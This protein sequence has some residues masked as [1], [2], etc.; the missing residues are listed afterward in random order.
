MGLTVLLTGESD[1]GEVGVDIATGE[2][3]AEVSGD[4]A[5]ESPLDED[6]Y[7]ADQCF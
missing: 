2:Q 7:K 1:M 5:K 3:H 6:R 4:G